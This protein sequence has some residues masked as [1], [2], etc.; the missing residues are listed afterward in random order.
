MSEI[1][2]GIE[3]KPAS[4]RELPIRTSSDR[5]SGGYADGTDILADVLRRA[6]DTRAKAIHSSDDD[7]SDDD[8]DAE[9]DD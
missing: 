3:L 1:R 2:H 4:E 5:N 6:L 7:D 9:W 8:D